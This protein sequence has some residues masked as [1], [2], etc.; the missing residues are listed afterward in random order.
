MAIK[1][2]F[3]VGSLVIDRNRKELGSGLVINKEIIPG[4][5]YYEY[6]VKFEHDPMD[7]PGRR[8]YGA[9]RLAPD[10]GPPANILQIL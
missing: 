7:R 2:D 4:R 6:S 1:R 5:S 3:N 10:K 9:S 8:Y